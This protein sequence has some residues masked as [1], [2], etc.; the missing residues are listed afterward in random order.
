MR[1]PGWKKQTCHSHPVI[2]DCDEMILQKTLHY[3]SQSIDYE[4][5]C[6]EATMSVIALTDSSYWSRG[7]WAS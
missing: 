1:L 7:H 5:R 3:H 6:D 2:H 4:M